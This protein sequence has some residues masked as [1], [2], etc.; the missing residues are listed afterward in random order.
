MSFIQFT[1]KPPIPRQNYIKIM[2]HP[3]VFGQKFTPICRFFGLET[4]PSWPHI[5]SMTQYGSA[6]PPGEK[7]TQNRMRGSKTRDQ[8]V[9][10]PVIFTWTTV[11]LAIFSGLT[12][13]GPDF[14][15]AVF[16]R[17]EQNLPPFNFSPLARTIEV[18][19]CMMLDILLKNLSVQNIEENT[20]NFAV[21]S[22]SMRALI[23]K[24]VKMTKGNQV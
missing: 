5:P 8:P 14:F 11:N 3:Q 9:A 21:I 10:R 4:H 19:L 23:Q 24:F 15:P 16:P 6:P 7:H 1:R 13:F 20:A 12:L 18:K 17:G 22:I 2:T